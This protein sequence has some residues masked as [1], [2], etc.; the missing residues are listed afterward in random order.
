MGEVVAWF[1]VIGGSLLCAGQFPPGGGDEAIVPTVA[2]AGL[3]FP[4]VVKPEDLKSCGTGSLGLCADGEICARDVRS[5]DEV[6]D[7]EI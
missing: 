7:G 6:N 1:V 2:E 4:P 3:S 5:N